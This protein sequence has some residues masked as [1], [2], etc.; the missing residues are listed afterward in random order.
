MEAKDKF[1]L[2]EK[3]STGTDT[4]SILFEALN[5]DFATEN[6]DD[7]FTPAKLA[8]ISGVYTTRDRAISE[9]G[10]PDPTMREFMRYSGHARPHNAV[11]S[12][13][14]EVAPN[15]KK[16]LKAAPA[17]AS[18]PPPPISPA[19]KRIM[20]P[21]SSPNCNAAACTTRITQAPP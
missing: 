15:W 19:A 11:V 1:S 5:F 4:H 2:I 17:T 21:M 12:G 14:K 3:L 18:P 20:S 9:T 16:C 7:P 13:P 8:S 6:L 10:R